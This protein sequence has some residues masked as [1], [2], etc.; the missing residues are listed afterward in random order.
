MEKAWEKREIPNICGEG[1]MAE[2]RA[3]NSEKRAH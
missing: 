3:E 1:R 2:G